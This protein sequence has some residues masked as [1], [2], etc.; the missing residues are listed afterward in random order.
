MK[1]EEGKRKKKG[2]FVCLFKLASRTWH[3][4][5]NKNK[6]HDNETETECMSGA[7]SPRPWGFKVVTGP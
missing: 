1:R 4:Q 3:H 6:M 2:R 5:K 7:P